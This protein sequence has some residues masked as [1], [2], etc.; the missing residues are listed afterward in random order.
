MR[1]RYVGLGA[2]AAL[3]YASCY[4]AIKE[5]FAYAP[6]LR[7]AAWRACIGGAL[8]FALLVVRRQSL[9]PTRRLWP[10]AMALAVVGPVIGFLAMFT[11]PRHSGVALS[12]VL[13][14]TG[15]LLII[16]LAK[17]FLAEP[18][19]R[20]KLGA[21]ALGLAGVSMIA[22]AGGDASSRASLAAIAVPLLA[23]ASGASESVIVKWA[24]PGTEVLRIAAWQYFIGSLV[25]FSASAWL[26][27]GELISWSTRFV[28]MLVLLAG[29]HDG[30]RHGHLVLA[31]ATRTA[32]P[33]VVDSSSR[34]R[35]G[36][37]RSPRSVRRTG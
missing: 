7:F 23:A 34:S 19:T 18:L 30:R 20:G 24:R 36:H 3:L 10:V 17:I 28:L 37:R 27:P 21:L 11:S 14:N 12:S 8:L 35:G 15:P 31:R 16:V 25:L 9:L 2:V 4:V 26:E 22:F 29:R 5:G 33:L 13:G 32:G 6:P 1:A